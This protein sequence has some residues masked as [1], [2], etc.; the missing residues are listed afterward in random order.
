MVVLAHA[1]PAGHTMHAV[2]LT[3]EKEP[4]VQGKGGPVTDGQALPAGQGVHTIAA[5]VLYEP[6]GQVTM[7]TRSAQLLPLGHGEHTAALPVA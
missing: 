4:L 5:A 7:V 1:E 6:R 2:A 3:R